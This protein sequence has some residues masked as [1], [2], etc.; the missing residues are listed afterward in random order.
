VA[1]LAGVAGAIS[2][3]HMSELA[4]EHGQVGWKSAAFPISVDGL[5]L[6]ASLFLL[7]Q[8]RSG[9]RT[10]VLPWAA[11]LVG[12][13]ARTISGR[14]VRPPRRSSGPTPADATAR[15]RDDAGPASGGAAPLDIRAV[16]DLLPA[17]RSARVALAASGRALSREALADRMRDDGHA[18]SNARA[19]LLLKILRAEVMS[20]VG[21][22]PIATDGDLDESA[23]EAA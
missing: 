13:A 11:L 16:A 14:A 9:G 1:G 7:A 18:V 8:H 4:L 6:T 19:S 12:T 23:G 20:A 22:E 10:G 3:S 2:F 21:R 5:E 17:A 15:L